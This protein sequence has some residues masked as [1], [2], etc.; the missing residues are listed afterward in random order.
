MKNEKIAGLYRGSR[1]FRYAVYFLAVTLVFALFGFFVLPPVVK[2]I[3]I[4]QASKFLHRPVVVKQVR[5]NPFAMTLDVE[6][7]S[8]NEREGDELFAGFD[9][10]HVNF[11]SV[12]LVKRGLVIGEVRLVNPKFHVVRLSDNRYNF[13]DLL[14]QSASE[15]KA[16]KTQGATPLF[17]V[18]NIQLQGGGIIFDDRPMHEKHEIRDV[19][20][21]LPFVSNMAY[22]LDVFVEPAFSAVINGAMIRASGKSKPFA[23][24]LESELSLELADLKLTQYIDYLPVKLP[25]K[26]QAG[27]LD[28]AVKYKFTLDK[29]KGASLHVAGKT[30]IR[31]LE[32]KESN[33]DALFAFK[34]LDIELGLCDL[35]AGNFVVD[36][37][38]LDSPDISVRIDKK[39]ILNWTTLS[40]QN[41]NATGGVETKQT[42]LMDPSV[43]W[44]L[45]EFSIAGGTI[46]LQDDSR[47]MP[48]KGSI[49][50]F[51]LNLKK[52][53]SRGTES[54]E[55][56]A[57]FKINKRGEINVEGS[58][59]P[60]NLSADL[61]LGVKTFELLPFQPYFAEKLN[62]AV[63]RGQVTANGNIK[64][65]KAASADVGIEGAF[66][67]QATLGDFLAVDKINSADFLR[68]KSFY[69]GNIDV[70]LNPMSVSVGEIALSDFFAR[71]IVSPEGKLN[72]MQLVRQDDVPAAA[73]APVPVEEK[74][75]EE[76]KASA[77]VVPKAVA[78]K[79]TMPVK[80]GKITLQGGDVRF[81]D[82]FVK[83]NYTANLKKIGGRITG[84]SSEP[85]T[86]ANLDLRG[87][88]DNAA[89]LTIVAQINPLSVKPYLDLQAEIKGIEMTS[90]ST[91]AGKYA[92][93]AIDK[94]KLSLFVKY[95][96]ENDQLEAENRVFLDQLTFGDAIDS[97]DATKLPVRLAVSLLKNRNGEIDLNLP[98]SGSLND[99][100]FS[101]GGL[102]VK[103]IVNLL[104][105]AVTSPFA[106]LGSLFGGEEL[107]MI[108]FEAGRAAILPAAEK[109]LENLA[110]A[111]VDR[112]ALKL[113]ITGIFSP[114]TDQEGLK[115]AG[116]ERKVKALKREELTRKGVETNSA[117]TI[118]ISPE[119]YPI[120]LERVY[121][122]EKFPKP[123]NMIGMIKALPVE[124]MEKL[125]MTHTSVN[126]EDLR[127]LGDRRGKVVRDWLTEHQVPLERIF[128]LP[129]KV[130]E[131]SEKADAEKKTG[132][133]HA[134]FTLK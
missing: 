102:V 6:G 16:P 75:P 118:E 90:F 28:S 108:D 101:V 56:A 25:V 20:L 99:P 63:T 43:V 72:L 52:L 48:F 2:S 39:G 35:M 44:S 15:P 64:L 123:R 49:E 62:V 17:S 85:G 117:E 126:E 67:G 112:P 38:A 84:L 86:V 96:I 87:S 18:N 106:L 116:I 77:P 105:K 95:K 111:L 80:V 54:A 29:A 12:S 88:Y 74:T 58:V 1:V 26:L 78:D 122:A 57:R 66:S 107:S 70:S 124:E 114:E 128:L 3:A 30:S 131:G 46:R 45:G 4:E 89:P 31:N 47:K 13:S 130:A 51:D 100:Q 133:G 97:P 7:L 10:L 33:G 40:A 69:V 98:I 24:S 119:E 82:N 5:I 23:D 61:N 34:R 71:I 79:P 41:A 22:A 9:S 60:F 132:N 53:E 55:L 121:R 125:I 42:A 93:Y 104:V 92:G 27:T 83:P 81:T 76:G 103:V 11:E 94:G 19:N 21:S 8:I 110:K 129:S 134:V 115:Q 59:N 68:W 50:A 120:L 65:R 91:Y 37:I 127:D 113:E 36:R 32:V 73:Q 109:R 14:E